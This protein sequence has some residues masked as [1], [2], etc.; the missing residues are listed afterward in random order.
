MSAFN[1][2]KRFQL[3]PKGHAL[4]W[5]PFGWLLFLPLFF[6]APAL[7]P[8]SAARWTA[9]GVATGLFLT[10]YFRSYWVTGAEL[11]LHVFLQMALGMAFSP[12]NAG[13]YILFV[14]ATATGARA[15]RAREGAFWILAAVAAGLGTASAT[16][17]PLS[18]WTGYG[19]WAGCCAFTM[20]I[21]AVNLHRT[22]SDR[23][24]ERLRAANQEIEQLAAIA[25]RERIA[26]DLH[27][28]LGHTLSLIVIKAQLAS[29]LAER[30]PT[31]AA[32]E[33]RDVEDV[34][35]QALN[36]VR[37]AIRGYRARLDDELIRARHLLDAAGI[38]VVVDS[39][40]DTEEFEDREAAEETLALALREAVTNIVRHSEARRA[41]VRAWRETQSATLMLEVADD[42]VGAPS[43]LIREG[44]GIRGMR[45]R[46]E[47]LNGA[48]TVDAT[49]TGMRVTVAL[50]T[51]ADEHRRGTALRVVAS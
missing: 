1:R 2:L 5:T 24:N 19:V 28:V 51:H 26:R 18:A 6:V 48:L 46:V 40:I 45:E 21:G 17:A 12:I 10:S 23:V 49:H 11:R 41:T 27:D 36:E 37:Q 8:T 15:E 32:R 35:R 14:F 30:D 43:N 13:S 34:S 25:E 16:R 42:G 39:S 44:N 20:L 22:Q 38:S 4:G 31:R 3:L 7:G 29:R 9:Y 33:I 47:K 50:P